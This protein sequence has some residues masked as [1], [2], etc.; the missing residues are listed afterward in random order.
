VRAYAVLLVPAERLARDYRLLIFSRDE[1]QSRQSYK[2]I[3]LD[4]SESADP[5]NFL[6]RSIRI[7][8]YFDKPSVTKFRVQAKDGVLFVDSAEDEYEVDVYYWAEGQFRSDR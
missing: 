7:A 6:I 3:V 4:Q 5:D 1:G 8:D 2:A